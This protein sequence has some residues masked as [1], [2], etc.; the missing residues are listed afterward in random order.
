MQKVWFPYFQQICSSYFTLASEFKRKP[1]TTIRSIGRTVL[2]HNNWPSWTLLEACNHVLQNHPNF[3][4]TPWTR[5]QLALKT[6]PKHT[7]NLHG[8]PRKN[9]PKIRGFPKFFFMF[10]WLF[11]QIKHTMVID[12]VYLMLGAPNMA[13]KSHP[14]SAF[15]DEHETHNFCVNLS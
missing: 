4:P 5:H 14:V 7:Q 12:I 15:C 8:G 6:Y 10:Y 1:C 3:V 13:P 11:W 2:K 9:N